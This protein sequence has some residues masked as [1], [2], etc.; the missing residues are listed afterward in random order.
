MPTFT[1]GSL[2]NLKKL[3]P[4]LQKLFVEAIKEY[5]FIISDSMRG[6][7]AQTKAFATGHSKVKFG[8]SAHNWNPGLAAD[9]YPAP[10]SART[11]ISKF[12][13]MQIKVIKPLAVRL[14]I[15][16]RQG[17]DFNMNGNLSD[18]KWDD[19]P[20]VELFPWREFAKAAKLFEG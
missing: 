9:I 8:Q 18:D 16:I 3:H 12:E 13:T 6:R 14:K 20:H 10:F 17:I 4:L 19:A 5:D 2:V 1:T 7:I 15:P 11:P